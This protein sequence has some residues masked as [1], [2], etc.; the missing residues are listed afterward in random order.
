M[1][2]HDFHACRTRLRDFRYVIKR[3]LNQTS[4]VFPTQIYT[5]KTQIYTNHS[6]Y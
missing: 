1:T 5:K 6:L 4:Y 3:K 2:K